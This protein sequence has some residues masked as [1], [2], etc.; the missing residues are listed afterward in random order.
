VAFQ[1]SD[2]VSGIAS[3]SPPQLVTG[4]GA[5]LSVTGTAENNA[6][7][8]TDDTANVAI[9]R[10]P[11]TITAAA[12]RAPNADGWYSDDV[13]VAFDCKD[14]LSGVAACP[15][16]VRL[17][18]GAGQ[19]A[20][21][22]ATDIAG[23][24]A[25]ATLSGIDVDK[26]APVVTYAGNQGTYSVADTVEITCAATDALS[27][28]ASSTCADISGPAWQF[29]LGVTNRSATAIDRAGNAGSASVSF[30]VGVTAA[31]LET[32]IGRLVSDPGV[33]AALQAKVEAVAAAPNGNAKAGKVAAFDNQVDAQTGKA[34]GA[35]DAALLEQLVAAL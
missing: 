14:A 13:V 27:G 16:P 20:A 24:T 29:G 30:S 34:I 1:C 33:A 10:T 18:E 22:T 5:S 11:P 4:E 23:N 7:W 17:G 19:S 26:T 2:S 32:L 21:G 8:T 31:S 12:D 6:G 9:D 3:C 28:V 35:A 25:N 15:A